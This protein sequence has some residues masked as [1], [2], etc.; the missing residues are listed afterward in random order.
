MEF[1][2]PMTQ[3]QIDFLLWRMQRSSSL[4][5]AKYG[6]PFDKYGYYM[7]VQIPTIRLSDGTF[8]EL[9]LEYTDR[10]EEDKI[11][12]FD[13]KIY[14]LVNRVINVRYFTRIAIYGGQKR[15]LF[16]RESFPVYHTF[17]PV[18][19]RLP[20]IR[21]VPSDIILAAGL[22]GGK[23]EDIGH[24]DYHSEITPYWVSRDYKTYLKEIQR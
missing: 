16:N 1:N 6:T 12:T 21:R 15:Y 9:N 19:G 2:V 24:I 11:I 17:T 8:I 22:F 23:P 14:G 5:W 4:K 7:L 3:K 18:K 20:F 13:N 10:S